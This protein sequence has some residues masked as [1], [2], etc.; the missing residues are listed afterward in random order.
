MIRNMHHH[1][2]LM[3]NTKISN[4]NDLEKEKTKENSDIMVDSKGSDLADAKLLGY[5]PFNS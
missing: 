1:S 5:A 4:D 2:L 3:N